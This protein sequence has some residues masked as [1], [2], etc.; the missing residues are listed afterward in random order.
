MDSL[1]KDLDDRLDAAGWGLFFV[2]TGVVLLVPA[3]PDGTWLTSTGVIIVGAAALR[4]HL[5]LSVNAF[6]TT[7]GGGFVA[8]GLGAM[9]G[10]A[11]PWFALLTIVCGLGLVADVVAVRP[12][13]A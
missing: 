1:R 7:L 9:A 6:W 8:L 13:R 12:L 3:L 2:M 10:L 5:G 4:A 11:L